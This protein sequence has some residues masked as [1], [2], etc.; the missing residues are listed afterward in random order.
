MGSEVV[1][2]EYTLSPVPL[3]ARLSLVATTMLWVSL[4]LDPSAPYLASWWGSVFPFTTFVAGV[5]LANLVLSIF[6]SLSGYM[7]SREGLTYALTAE[8]VYGSVGVVVP[9]I[10]AGIVCVGWLAFSIGVVADGFTYI[11][12]LPDFL[13]YVLAVVLTLLFSVTAYIGVRAIV[14]L[15]YVGVPL[16]VI[17]IISGTALSVSRW[18]MP[19]IG[20]LDVTTLPLIFGL[21][22]GTFVNGSIVLSFDYQRFCK[23]PLDAVLTA[24]INFL[25]FWS[26]IILL[27]GIP[28]ALTGMDLYSAYGVLGLSLLALVT[29]FLL[30][31]TSAD[32]QLY[33]ASLSW[34]LGLKS[35]GRITERR[36]ILIA[37]TI[38][39]IILALIKLHTFAIQW[40]SLLTSISLP[41]GI[42]LWTE[43][44]VKS[45]MKLGEG[46]KGWNIR[47]F[48][49]WIL[50]S[51]IIYY[52]HVIE[53][54]WYG[55][56]IGFLIT[57]LAYIIMRKR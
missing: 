29:L 33:S 11:A 7:A 43:Y 37:A 21:V 38:L 5:L 57:S 27:T 48:A 25:G 12:G 18:G 42:V 54:L 22:L 28:A 14:K 9:S 26:F 39:T 50:G 8:R 49:S 32:N 30:A 17:L 15:A 20:A 52:L 1:D 55:L 45:R 24:F 51:L 35:L 4:T 6:S 53:G 56:I 31:W 36:K 44:Y 34:T 41:A 2:R 16:L 3:A 23:K 40:L 13:Y 19:S 47:A 46:V 10:W